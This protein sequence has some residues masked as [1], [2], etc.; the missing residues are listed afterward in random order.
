M[1]RIPIIILLLLIITLAK[2]QT[3]DG[4]TLEIPDDTVCYGNNNGI[5]VL[6]SEVGDVQYWEYSTS[7]ASPWIT[8]NQNHDTLEYNNLTET[9]YFRAIVKYEN[10]E[11]D[12]STIAVVHVSPISV[13]GTL[14]QDMEVCASSN[15]ETLQLTGYTGDI[16]YWEYSGDNGTTWNSIANTNGTYTFTNLLTTNLFRVIVKS[17]VCSSDTSNT[18]TVKVYPATDAGT[19]SQ[20]DSVCY[21]NN[22]GEAILSSFTGNIV[23]WETSETGYA[24]WSTINYTNDTLSYTNLVSTNYYR[25]VVKSGVCQEEISNE[26]SVKVSPITEGG[27][28]S[29][30]QEVCSEVNSGTVVLSDYTGDILNWQYSH[31]FG[32]T[33]TDTANINHTLNY[34]GLTQTTVFRA[35]IR[36]GA[37]DT[38]YSE[39]STITVNPLPDVEFSYDTVCR[40]QYTTFTNNSSIVT[41]SISTY[42]WNFG[43][44]DGNNADNAVYK[45]PVD[46]TYTVKLTAT[47]NKGCIDSL[48]HIVIVN[49]SPVVNFSFDNECD[50]DTVHFSNSSFSTINGSISYSWDFGDTTSL[51][52]IEN[53]SHLYAYSNDYPAKLVV[54]EDET[55]CKDSLIK[56]VSVYPRTV[57]N[58]TFT[59]VCDGNEMNFTNQTTVSIG[60]V[61]YYWTFGDGYYDNNANPSHL[62]N[63][64][65]TYIVRMSA[66]TENNCTDTVTK[67]VIVFAQPTAEFSGDDICYTDTFIFNNESVINSGTMSYLWNFGSG[68]TS[69]QENPHYYYFSPGTYTVSLSV[70]SDSGCTSDVFHNVNVYSLPNVLFDV[71][72]KCLYD[73]A[74]FVNNSTIQSGTLDYTWNFGDLSGSVIKN[75]SHKYDT[76]GTYTVKLIAI[77]GGM[78]SDSISKDV[79]I[80]P[81]PNPDFSAANVCDG[82]KSYFYD[83]T[84]IESGSIQN[85]SWDFGDGTNSVQQ[86]PIQQFL[87]PGTYDVRLSVVSNNSCTAQITKPVTVDF[88]PIA[89]FSVY[90]VCENNPISPANSSTIEE[91]S[92]TYLWKFGN[93]DTSIVPE[94]NYLYDGSGIFAV[95]LITRSENGCLDSL[96]RNVQVYP[97]P[98]ANAGRDTSISKGDEVLLNASGGSIYNWMPST[99]LSNSG[100]SNPTASPTETIVYVV[101]VEDLNSCINYDTV[102]VSVIDDYKISPNNLITPNGDGINDVWVIDNIGN[103]GNATIYIYDRWGNEIYAKT[104]YDNS[105]NGTNSNGDLLPD[106]T[107]YYLITFDD[108]DVNYKGAISILRDN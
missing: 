71:D 25:A 42:S 14:S 15:S 31:D 90:N 98:D 96:I 21:G 13:A 75:P 97:L 93:G 33:W 66:T 22:Y 18:I 87:N 82:E 16:D 99:G 69:I 4:G 43:N 24:P 95:T 103:Y 81:V 65:G 1:K 49:P 44:G 37:C 80:F 85:Y 94:P 36:S 104:A 27:I 108:S 106:G 67:N 7:G 41:G 9:T 45:Y 70:V 83:E 5:L 8:I 64:D 6:N 39:I 11:Q 79:N 55:G 2:A 61:N 17:G 12:T 84:T 23:R 40:G 28:L 29:G 78:C 20:N 73:S 101:Q 56:T 52:S 102:K 57:P 47:S 35:V 48:K 3:S 32:T 26:I 92:I 54:T 50:R 59:N 105:W 91:G 72:D 34:S 46:G 30:S 51:V 76:A 53:P 88:M 74:V 62:Y 60:N 100:V 86:N 19:L 38:A 77:A 63:T 58:F 107:Y 10:T 68:D 89:N